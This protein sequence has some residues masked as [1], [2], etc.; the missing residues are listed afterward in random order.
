MLCPGFGKR[1]IDQ[2]APD[3]VAAKRFGHFGMQE[4]QPIVVEL[5]LQSC[6]CPVHGQNE[7]LP[8]GIVDDGL[9]HGTKVMRLCQR[10]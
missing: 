9:T 6:R 5:V 7:L 4:V 10:P 2:L 1:R 8:D 3:A